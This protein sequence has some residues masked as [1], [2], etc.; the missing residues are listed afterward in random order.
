MN[1][2]SNVLENDSSGKRYR[3]IYLFILQPTQCGLSATHAHVPSLSIEH[4]EWPLFSVGK[5]FAAIGIKVSIPCSGNSGL[6]FAHHN[7]SCS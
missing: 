7:L 1:A 4:L 3:F 5:Q 6:N 2:S